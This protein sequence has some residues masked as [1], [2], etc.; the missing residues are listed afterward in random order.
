MRRRHVFLL[1]CLAI[2]GCLPPYIALLDSSSALT[3][4][5]TVAGTLGPLNMQTE[6]T[7]IRFLPMKPTATSIAGL[8]LQSGFTIDEEG[9][10]DYLRFAYVDSSGQAQMTGSQPFPLDVSS[11]S[12]PLYE[13]DVT[14]TTTTA[15][16]VVLKMNPTNS[17][18]NNAY[19][20]TA[21]LPSG[22]LASPPASALLNTV[23]TV[24]GVSY[25]VL[26]AHVVP[27]PAAADTFNSLLWDGI[28]SYGVG[29]TTVSVPPSV[30]VA[31]TG[32]TTSNPLLP[33]QRTFYYKSGTTNYASFSSGGAWVC[34][35]WTTA[36]PVAL[37]GVTHRIDA[38][39]TTGDLL[40]TEG[41][42]LRLY[43][44]TGS[45]VLSVS[46]GGL[47]FCYEAYLGTTPYVF[48]SLAMNL[49]RGDWIFRVY[50]IPT[51]SMRSLGG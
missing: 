24:A 44:P 39:L 8:N 11:P 10:Y 30:F 38:V 27:L 45:Q 50:A 28:A 1:G 35:Q 41:G 17:A 18:L 32:S 19:L 51:S 13:F 21:T 34:E 31:T 42:I 3:R 37:S 9:A 12:Y 4:Q 33:A 43:D 48:F 2:A 16:I 29:S 22:P 20:C 14:T 49:Q 26:G 5:M 23:F 15:N 46:L 40:S 7:N 25:A 47:Q 6:S 36:A